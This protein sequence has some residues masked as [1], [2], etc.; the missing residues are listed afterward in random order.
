MHC[1]VG[2][3][4]RYRQ[5]LEDAVAQVTDEEFFQSVGATDNAIATLVKHLGGNL[6]SRFTDF[7]TSD[8]E[9][10][11]RNREGEFQ[12][13]DM[14]REA[15]MAIW[16]KGWGILETNVFALTD[17]DMKRTVTIRGVEFTVEEALA[18]SLGH[19][20][21]HVGQIVFLAKMF[22]GK[23]WRY[24]S[25]PP[26]QSDAYNQNPTMEKGRPEGH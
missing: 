21:Y 22:R 20:S 2:E 15:V 13:A 1:F 18:R 14:S 23:D 25:I 26:G 5:L 16:Q 4:K 12:V 19:L 3:F 24:L 7:L 6:T 10:P 17:A 11:W 8:G 9:K